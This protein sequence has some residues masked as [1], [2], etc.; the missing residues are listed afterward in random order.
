MLRVLHEVVDARDAARDDDGAGLEVGL[1]E[2]VRLAA[3]DMIAV[4]LEAER[5]AYIDAH[6]Q[7]VDDAGRRL[8]VGNG[9]AR[10][11][12][13]VTAAG[14]VEVVAPRVHDRRDWG[15]LQLGAV[16][17]V[18]SPHPKVTEVLP[19]LYLRGLSTNDFEPAL[20]G[21][22]G[23]DAGLSAS[24]VQRL[25]EA[26]RVERERWAARSLAEVDY[27]YIWADGVH[28]NVRLPDGD[29]ERDALCLLV[30]VGVRLD[31]TKELV[32]VVDGYRESTGSWADLLRDLRDRGM[33]APALAVGDGALGLWAALRDTWPD[34][35]A[36]RCWVHYADVRVMPTRAA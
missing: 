21:F 26:W 33:A 20:E 5:R 14:A 6:A 4:A 7:L 10:P 36:Q 19:L 22:F 27:V 15:A 28:V 32:A 29:G 12:E 8:V 34:T 9:Y 23:S 16:A 11:R 24:T 35:K 1:D 31:G 25:T 2:L 17:A 18:V 30:I 3:R 13:V